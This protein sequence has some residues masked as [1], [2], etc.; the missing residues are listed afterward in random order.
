MTT[1]CLLADDHPALTWTISTY[2]SEHGFA[3]VGPATDGRQTVELAAAERPALAL[4]DYRM[5]RLWGMELVTALRAA[6]AATRLCVYTA[7][8]DASLARDL[9]DA[10]ASGLVLKE[11]PLPS[12]VRALK[13]VAAGGEYVDPALAGSAPAGARLT[14]RELDVLRLLAEGLRQE[15]IGLR[16]G[17][18]PETVRT[19][20]RKACARLGAGTRTQAVATA[21]RH[22]LIA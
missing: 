13:T 9:I 10:G 3:I 14:E 6:S 12:V 20:L 2:L 16:L 15:E 17:I 18:G 19:H 22:G 4:V 21:L 7:D 1:T 11:S 5:P 8:A